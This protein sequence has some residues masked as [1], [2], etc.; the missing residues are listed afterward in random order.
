MNLLDVCVGSD[1][2]IRHGFHNWL[3]N[4]ITSTVFLAN[5]ELPRH[6]CGQDET[7]SL[8]RTKFWHLA[9]KSFKKGAFGWES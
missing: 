9:S 6:F 1:E 8:L 5:W 2:F 4:L 7:I 3:I